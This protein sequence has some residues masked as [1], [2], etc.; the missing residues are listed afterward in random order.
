MRVFTA[1]ARDG[2]PEVLLVKEGFSWP[3]FLFQALW[4]LWHRMWG[5]AL[6]LLGLGIAAEGLGIAAGLGGAAQAALSLGVAALIG[7]L[8]NDL[9]RHGLARRGYA[10]SAVVAGRDA[11]A[12]L[13]R[14]LEHRPELI[15]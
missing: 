3:A 4:A 14:L 8:G 12:A 15:A 11:D 2:D 9:R 10:E 1:H 6:G 5:A 7:F 13:H